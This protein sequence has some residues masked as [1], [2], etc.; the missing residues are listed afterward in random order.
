MITKEDDEWWVFC[1]YC[2]NS[3]ELDDAEDFYE[4]VQRSRRLGFQGETDDDGRWQNIC[5][6][7]QE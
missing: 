2:S 7:C 1:D 3:A 5:P 4:A 6:N